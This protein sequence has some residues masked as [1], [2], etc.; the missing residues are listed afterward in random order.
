LIGAFSWRWIFY[1]NLPIGIAGSLMV[2]RFVPNA[3]PGGEQR[4]D[5]LGAFTLF[6]SLAA[7]LLGLTLG[8]RVGFTETAIL[9]LFGIWLLFLVLFVAIERSSSHPMIDL[10]L[11]RNR[12]FSVN[13]ITGFITFVSMG[14]TLILMPFY[15]ENVL[16]YDP[17]SVGLLLA[18]VPVAMGLTAPL[19]GLLSDRLGTRPITVVG[20][21][22]LLMGFYAIS[23][24]SI[25]T[26]ALGYVLRFLPIGIGMGIFQSPNNSAIMGSAPRARLGVASGLLSITRA[27]GQT[28][29]IAVL[30]ALWASRVAYHLGVLPPGGA[31]A[32]PAATQVAGLRNTF[33]FIII[34]IGL[35]LLLGVWGLVQERRGERMPEWAATPAQQNLRKGVD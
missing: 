17:R 23:T 30:G 2:A 18:I 35:A 16:G 21:A 12:L 15:L 22:V 13:L 4:F 20:L 11:F 3:K 10:S 26:T 24:L 6:I 5:Y 33:S 28:T 8:Q 9:T 25:Q 29:G 34:L 19:A 32:A 27:L 7:L 31:T 1:V 14:G